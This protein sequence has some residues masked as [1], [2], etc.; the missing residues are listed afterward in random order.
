M[1]RRSGFVR[2]SRGQKGSN[3]WLGVGGVEL[4]RRDRERKSDRP[5]DRSRGRLTHR[6]SGHER[7]NTTGAHGYSR[8]RSLGQQVLTSGQRGQTTYM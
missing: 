5:T 8:D 6:Q 3:I 2:T 7:M 4:R 1:R